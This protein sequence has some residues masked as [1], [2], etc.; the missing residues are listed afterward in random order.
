MQSSKT[1]GMAQI[2]NIGLFRIPEYQ[3][4][5]VWTEKEVKEFL[6]DIEYVWRNKEDDAEHYL[7]SI[8]IN[9]KEDG[10]KAVI[11]GQQ[12]LITTALL[13]HQIVRK[14]KDLD[15]ESSNMMREEVEDKLWEIAFKE[16][17][18]RKKRRVLP[19][20]EQ[21]DVFKQ[22][23][24][25]D[26][27]E[28]RNLEKIA[29][30][31]TTP[32]GEK[33]IEASDTIEK[34]IEGWLG[35]KDDSKKLS[36]EKPL[37]I[38]F[39]LSKVVNQRLKATVHPVEDAEE[40]GRMFEAVNDRGRDLNRADR[41]KSYLV[42]RV[43][44]NETIDI[45][46]ERIQ[47]TFSVVYETLNEYLDDPEDIDDEIERLIGA[48]WNIFA[49]ES[50]IKEP[51]DEEKISRLEGRHQEVKQDIDQIKY[52]LYH[53]SKKR[54]DSE[55]ENWIKKYLE[56][57]KESAEIYRKFN[58]ITNKAIYEDIIEELHDDVDERRVRHSLYVAKE[59][60]LSIYYS[61]LIS[62]LQ[63]FGDS[64]EI[65]DFLFDFE[66]MVIRVYEVL[67]ARRD[68]HR[69]E[70]ESMSRALYW[71][72]NQKEL[73]EVLGDSHLT[74]KIRKEIDEGT[75]YGFNGTEEDLQTVRENLRSW[76]KDYSTKKTEDDIV[77]RFE[78]RLATRNL[79][80]FNVAEWG[81]LRSKQVKN[82]MMYRYVEIISDDEGRLPDKTFIESDISEG[83]IEHVWSG[84]RP[85]NTSESLTE[86]E[87]TDLIDRIG[88]FAILSLSGNSS[89]GN[90][91]YEKKW[92][93]MYS[94]LKDSSIFREEFPDPKGERNNEATREC[95]G[96]WGADIIEWRSE[97]I[98]E[99]LS[100]YWSIPDN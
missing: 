36:N 30:S 100:D 27:T 68:A 48:H 43:S 47:S 37:T 26:V 11:D 90:E 75:G 12:R 67:G 89:L 56:S 20:D 19:A 7:G 35:E 1:E 4:G 84:E 3:R 99:K 83:T 58:G 73:E 33:L 42:Y 34:R 14:A 97:R 52:S 96:G 44:H 41:I 8:I 80:G 69:N 15:E 77:D 51:E 5:Y 63:R 53:A 93:K 50:E 24:P 29:D 88:N 70:F 9:E 61:L 71:A 54:D 59:Y 85:K 23:Y 72:R 91:P 46:P 81:G 31:A 76:T 62:V 87:Y 94:D 82:Y 45:N 25:K 10:E 38:L 2:M 21:K 86:E 79:D 74:E 16:T 18:S 49:G 65:E 22:I 39:Q 78:R 92:E 28:K 55:V 60:G 64:E 17:G 98:A 13:S 32:S 95:G 66:T 40:A 57:L 6:D